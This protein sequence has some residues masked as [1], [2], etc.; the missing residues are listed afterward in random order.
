V[1]TQ[2]NLGTDDIMVVIGS[3]SK[4]RLLQESYNEQLCAARE[5]LKKF[6]ILNEIFNN[7]EE[8]LDL[9]YKARKNK[10]SLL[11]APDSTG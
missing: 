4:G 7:F 9:Y 3:Y 6:P 11:A 10:E 5:R 2:Y 1:N 8:Y